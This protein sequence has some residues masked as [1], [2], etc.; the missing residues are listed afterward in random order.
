M[1]KQWSFS[2]MTKAQAQLSYQIKNSA[3]P[4]FFLLINVD[5][6][7]IV[8]ILTFMSKKNSILALSELER[9]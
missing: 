9:S 7:T 5:I 1:C 3:E 2:R 4:E 8:D 6:P